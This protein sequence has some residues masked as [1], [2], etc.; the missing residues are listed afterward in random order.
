[1]RKSIL[2]MD[3]ASQAKVE[4]IGEADILVGISSY[5]NERTIAHVIKAVEYGLVK[6]FPGEKAVIVNSD[7][8]STDR[9]REIVK[10]TSVYSDLDTLLIKHPTHPASKI[11]GTYTGIPGKGSAFRAIF[12]VASELDV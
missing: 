10:E 5:N 6:Y 12:E 1:M 2:D 7:G 11:V 9:T 4:E 8:G 3:D